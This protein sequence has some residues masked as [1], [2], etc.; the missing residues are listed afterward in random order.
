MLK[1]L[2]LEDTAPWKVRF[3]IPRI[4][5]TQ[6]AIKDS[7]RGLVPC[8]KSGLF[9]L[10]AWN[11]A[12]G[13]LTQLTN[14]SDGTLLGKISPDGRFVYYLNDQSGKEIGHLFRVPFEGDEPEDI[15]PDMPPYQCF[16]Y[17]QSLSNNFFGFIAADS[18]GF[19]LYCIDLRLNGAP[20]TRRLVYSSKNIIMGLCLS[21]N[22]NNA[23]FASTER[24]G[25][26]GQ[27]NLVAIDTATGQTIAE[28]ED[29]PNTSIEP[30]FFSRCANDYRVIVT[31]NKSGVRK[32]FIWN[33]HTS[34]RHDLH[35]GDL[36]NDI[37]VLDWSLDGNK[38]LLCQYSQAIQ[39][40]Y[41]YDLVTD[42]LI[43]LNHPNGTFTGTCFAA[44]QQI[45]TEWQ[46]AANCPQVIA[47]D[48]RTGKKTQ[49]LLSLGEVPPSRPWKSITYT[50]S[51]GQEIQGWLC[52]P[53]SNG[54]FP[55]IL[56]VHGGPTMVVSEAY[57][58]GCQAC[59]DHG[60]AFLS[61]N[62]RGST[63]FGKDFQN[64]ILADIGHWELEDMIAA[65]HWLIEQGIAKA[66][67]VIITGGSYGG[68]LTLLAMGK[69]PDLW[70]GG[71]AQAA[72][73]DWRM[74]M[75]DAGE[76]SRKADI[77]L[78]GVSPEENPALY[79]RC[80]PI[81]YAANVKKPILILQGRNDTRTPARQIEVYEERLK[82][83][84]KSI[85]VYWYE[86]GHLSSFGQ[87]EHAIR[88][89]EIMF[90]FAY[91]VLSEKKGN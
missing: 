48:S 35:I 61:I 71:I 24:S 51:D 77:A 58:R 1:P 70:A 81:T 7:T 23:I 16:D 14:R 90:R 2:Q 29:G 65:H 85:E 41:V 26:W 59:V 53:D 42:R 76:I 13:S 18:Q 57:H 84:G 60:F 45:I 50:S 66:N 54:P 5:N 32:P 17:V 86:A 20:G 68:Y 62:Y 64:K 8:N 15:T 37:E 31:T 72:I 36:E 44:D 47:L 9:Q 34:G 79:D 12:T 52:T 30:C 73:A 38:I 80:S 56:E 6:I 27:F 11:V 91:Q 67:Q 10:Y 25:K 69:E 22:G 89:Q 40:L 43:R 82:S 4:Y 33:V 19:H 49:N 55:T 28:L 87:T 74:K 21:Y 46:D 88:L 63:T 83:L 75:V 3:R 78:F 39:R